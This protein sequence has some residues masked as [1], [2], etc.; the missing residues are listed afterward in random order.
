[1]AKAIV[2]PVAQLWKKYQGSDSGNILLIMTNTQ[3]KKIK[4]GYMIYKTL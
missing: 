4:Q 3:K 1:M 2:S